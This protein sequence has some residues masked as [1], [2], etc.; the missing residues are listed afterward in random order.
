MQKEKLTEPMNACQVFC[1]N[2]DCSA[3]GQLNQGNI[4]IHDHSR[5]RYRCTVCAKTFTERTGTMFVG[6]KKSP[7][8]VETVISLL[9]KGCPVQAIVYTFNLDERTVAEWRDKAGRHCQ[10]MH[11][12]L[13]ETAGLDLQHVQADEIRAK[14]VG[15]VVW[16]A[17]AIMVPTRLW[18][19][20]V[21]SAQRDRR[22]IRRLM[23]LVRRCGR[24]GA[25]LLVCTDGLAAYPKATEQAFRDKVREPAQRGRPRLA[26]QPGLVIGRV[27]KRVKARRLVEIDRQILRGNEA[28]VAELLG[29]SAGG[30]LLLNTSYIERFNA[31][32]RECWSNLT[33]KSRHAAR[34]IAA[35]NHGM[36]LVGTVYNFC[37]PHRELRLANWD[38]PDLPRWIARSPAMA[39]GLSD[40]LWTMGEL[41]RYKVAPPPFVAPKRRGR[42]PKKRPERAFTV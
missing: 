26:V 16:L 11:Q 7:E 19:G 41:L 29:N 4:K 23:N 12:N 40:H 31:T 25:K 39:S 5:R 6:L 34:K 37:T 17:M 1:P 8:L 33:R 18:L 28:Q 30:G 36:Y 10:T 21:V 35:L 3:R 22:L 13:V 24:A 38:N 20:G 15:Q 2:L 9:S 42:P 27:I 14:T 32:L